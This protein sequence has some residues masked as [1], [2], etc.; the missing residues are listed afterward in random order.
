AKICPIY[1]HCAV[2][3][4]TVTCSQNEPDRSP[5]G[6]QVSKDACLLKHK[7]GS[8]AVT[9]AH[10]QHRTANHWLPESGL[11]DGKR[12]GRRKER[13]DTNGDQRAATCTSHF[14]LR[15]IWTRE[16][17]INHLFL[18]GYGETTQDIVIPRQLTFFLGTK[19]RRSKRSRSLPRFC[20]QLRIDQIR[21]CA[22]FQH[23]A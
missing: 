6:R 7:A 19:R 1:G 21:N 3:V 14:L 13:Q 17:N 11:I 23:A 22:R 16:V 8:A 18:R 10:R 9:Q 15:R 2:V 20:V 5:I 4:T 12:R